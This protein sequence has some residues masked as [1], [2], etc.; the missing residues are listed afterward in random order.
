MLSVTSPIGVVGPFAFQVAV[1]D[2]EDAM[3]KATVDATYTV[4]E[5]TPVE[6]PTPE[7]DVEPPPAEDT[8]APSVPTGLSLAV[9]PKS[10]T[11]SW[12]ASSDNVGVSGYYLYRDGKLIADVSSTSFA[13]KDVVK[14]GAYEYVV[15]AYDA[16]G[17]ESDASQAASTAAESS[18]EEPTTNTGKGRKK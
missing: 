12:N 18:A 5:E 10:V 7:P 4:E 17:N 2:L 8:D 1:S 13:D 14:G 15:T 16:A 6:E 11:A 3:H 9:K